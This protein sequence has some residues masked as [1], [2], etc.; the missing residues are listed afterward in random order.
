MVKKVIA[1]L[2]IITRR[3]VMELISYLISYHF[4]SVALIIGIIV[5]LIEN[6]K[7]R[8]RGTEHIAV[9]VLLLSIIVANTFFRELFY[10]TSFDS[11]FDYRGDTAMYFMY[12]R[13]TV[14]HILFPMIA[15]I[16]IL[17]ITPTV[18]RYL[19]FLPEGILIAAEIINLF[20]PKIVFSF[21][22]H[23]NYENRI[24]FLSPYFTGMIYML[25]LLRYSIRFFKTKDKTKGATVIFIVFLT[26]LECYL[27]AAYIVVDLMDEIV[28]LDVIIFYFY[29]ISIY[30]REM[31]TKLR[32]S[33]LELEK[34]RRV[35]TLSQIQP[36]FMY[37]SLT[38]IIYLCDKDPQK[39]KNALIDFSKYL[40]QNLDAMS[41]NCLVSIKEEL[42]HT[43]IY[44][45]L[46]KL[47]FD[48]DLN[49]EFDIKDEMFMLPVLTVQPMVENA[50]KH[51]IN[52]SESGCGTVR[53]STDETETHHRITITDD[54]AGFDT[55]AL[56]ELDES[57]IGI[58]N[59]RKRLE[60]ECGGE[61]IINSVPDK[62]TEC[63]IL[64]PK[65][66]DD[67]NSGN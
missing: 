16:E 7:E 61:L 31:E 12:F 46:E 60:D 13:T 24:F 65:E 39:T 40:R 67:E 66:K 11:S 63:V 18:K 32:T 10:K 26:I 4:V 36:H 27:E 30:Q 5:L 37:N 57:H 28:A 58:N 52:S 42:E 44:L 29:L 38:S 62:G 50:V 48:D 15:Y 9:I 25:L 3:N 53:V 22:R 34:S 19:L 1:V 56:D 49:I 33:E 21:D 8:P 43:K 35:L 59:V 45:S 41:R 6:R 51:G 14:E 17:L 54:G 2:Y 20:G 47:R 55:T 23:L 64:I